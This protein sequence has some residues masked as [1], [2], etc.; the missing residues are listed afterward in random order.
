MSDGNLRR[1]FRKHLPWVHWT[2]I[3]SRFTQSGI[4][5]LNGCWNG[6]EFWLECKKTKAWGVVVRPMQIAW[7]LRHCHAGGNCWLAVRRQTRTDDQLW[8]VPGRMVQLLAQQGL[9]AMPP[10]TYRFAGGPAKWP[11]PMVLAAVHNAAGGAGAGL[12]QLVHHTLPTT[13]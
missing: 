6:A 12:G 4:P 2:S 10:A 13:K 8:L 9:Q 7:L 11:W 1:E 5:D 3:E